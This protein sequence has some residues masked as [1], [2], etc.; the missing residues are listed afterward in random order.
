MRI[1]FSS[2]IAFRYFPRSW[3][4]LAARRLGGC[5]ERSVVRFASYTRGGVPA[6]GVLAPGDTA[7]IELSSLAP[8]LEALLAAGRDGLARVREFVQAG[9]AKPVALR[10]VTLSAPFPRPTRTILCVGKNYRDHAAE[11]HGSGFD[12]TGGAT[13]VPDAPIIFVKHPSSVIGPDAPIRSANDPTATVD[14]EGELAVIIGEPAFRVSEANALR[15]VYGYTIVNDVT[16]RELQSKHKQWFV[17]KSV[18]TFCPMGPY[19]VTA[20]EIPDVTRLR[21]KTFVNDELRQDALVADLIFDIPFLIA[22]L[23]ATTTLLPGD[24]IATGT[25]AGV[26]IGFTPPKYLHAG[27]RVRITIDGLGELANPVS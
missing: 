18:D 15:Y 4:L 20:D 25:P 13:A 27:D 5:E 16:S 26:G 17:G 12:S 21:L 3:A 23:S 10:D 1:S 2:T 6:F 14:Y 19:L 24:I 8:D 11:F 9:S 22:T 7:V